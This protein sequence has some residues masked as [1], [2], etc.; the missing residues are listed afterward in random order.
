[1]TPPINDGG[2]AFP[3]MVYTQ[4]DFKGLTLRDYFASRAM[5]S[6]II[7]DCVPG[8]SNDSLVATA[9]K[10]SQDPVC[11]LALTSYIFADAMLAAR[12]EK[13]PVPDV[14]SELLDALELI[15]TLYESDRE[16]GG[17][18]MSLDYDMRCIARAAITK[19]QGGK[20]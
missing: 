4:E 3:C 19:A 20:P 15:A 10:A 6:Q 17:R 2:P 7:T 12:Q 8:P 14:N 5:A 18:S 9:I 16:S 1:M 13:P 11:R